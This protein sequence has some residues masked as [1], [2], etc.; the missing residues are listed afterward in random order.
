MISENDTKDFQNK[1]SIWRKIITLRNVVIFPAHLLYLHVIKT[2]HPLTYS[3]VNS[4][5]N[6]CSLSLLF[7]WT[8]EESLH[9]LIK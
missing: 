5:W 6:T 9:A 4:L 8:L 2:D 3:E 1:N 7:R